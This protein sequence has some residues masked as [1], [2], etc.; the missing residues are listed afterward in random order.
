MNVI[1][2]YAPTNDSEDDQKDSFYLQLERV[3]NDLRDKDV[4][5]LMGDFNAKVGADNTG[6]EEIMG[7]HALGEMNDN[8]ERFAE[9]CGSN[10]F[11][12]GGS[13]F[14]HKRIH[15]ATWISPD[16]VTE[17]QIDHICISKKFRRSLID[18][19]VKRGADAASDHQLLTAKVKLKL[20]RLPGEQAYRTKYNV[21]ALR[22]E[23]TKTAFKLT[24][25]NRF[26]TLQDMMTEEDMDVH[27]LWD[28]TKD[29][30]K[31]TCQEELGP[32]K[33]QQ[34]EWIKEETVRKIEERKEKKAALNECKTR[35]KKATAQ[36]EYSEAHKQVRQ[37]IK[38]DKREF[39]E[40]LADQ[41]E[42]AAHN[43][44]MRELYDIGRRLTGKFSRSERPVKD[45]QGH[46]ITESEKQLD[47]WTEHF[48]ELLNRPAPENPP[49]I[50]EAEM[51]LDI[52]SDAPTKEEIVKAIKRLKNGKA[53]GPDGIPAEALKADV[54]TTAE[55]LLPLFRKIWDEE[56]I[57][58]DWKDGHIIKLPKKGD[59]SNCENYRGIT[60]LSIPGKIFNRILLE[61][62]KD[63]VD[64]ILRDNQ[65]GFRSNRSCT[66]Q[67]ATLRIIVEQSLEWNS[68]LYINFVD[69]R[70]AFDSIHRDTL[71]QLLRNYGIPEK[72]TRLIKKSYEDM[73][74]QV[75]HQGK[76]TRKFEVKTGV[77]QGCLLSPFLFL[78][79]IDWVMK[80]T[81][82]GARNGIQWTLWS[83]LDD[84]DFADD[85]ALLAHSQEQIQEKTSRLRTASMK[86]G[87]EIHPRKT[88]LMKMNTSSTDPVTLGG[89]R[90]EEVDSFTY[91]GSII[92]SQGGTDEDVKSRIGKARTA[93]VMLRNIWNSTKLQTRTKLRFFN[94]NVKAVLLY[95]SE[96]WRTTKA[97]T[98]RIQ[99][100]INGCLRRILHIHWPETITN[101]DLWERTG[102]IA[103][104][105]EIKRRRW[106]WIG[107]TLRK[108]QDTITRQALTWNPQGR[109]KRGRP[110]NSW[111]RDLEADTREIGYSWRE[112]ER[113]AQDRDRWRSAVG[114]LCSQGADGH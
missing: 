8:G 71:W 46:N 41:A 72:V 56:E 34:K 42:Q 110:R 68:S 99:T 65:A 32:Q 26:Q 64:E 24:L 33:R 13:I 23:R 106:R 19:R 14:P 74:C 7:R 40:D 102:Q 12:I 67:I 43:G 37:S 53:A 92:N 58:K 1:R 89:E 90:L 20:R 108:R 111:R 25:N 10:N 39:Y 17:N 62:M 9:V 94:S 35:A 82:E 57:P 87:L 44:N 88:Q 15:K 47:R 6:Y 4:N 18:V 29:A 45:K 66:D 30:V 60:L 84:L 31:G 51:D 38:N 86:V 91:L 11:V 103:A 83:Q 112:L 79:A 97:T 93:F 81:T 96:T 54:E 104:E 22:D 55:M 109:R 98:K 77:R 95:G 80:Q 69:Y 5:I 2:C 3:L 61:R 85:L 105:E 63:S 52:N 101:K 107:H 36:E 73:T 113:L 70:K 49:V 27:T 48:E 114:G 59:L 100:F 28:K 16:Q 78:L 75:V 21:N 50:P 76:L